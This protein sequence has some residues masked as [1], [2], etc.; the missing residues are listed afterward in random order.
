MILII[1]ILNHAI[2]KAYSNNIRNSNILKIVTEL[3]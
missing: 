1:I 2:E 3:I